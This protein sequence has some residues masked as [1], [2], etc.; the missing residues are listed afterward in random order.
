MKKVS[1]IIPAYNKA[2]YTLSTVQSVIAQTYKDIEIIV[3]DDGSTDKTPEI[4]RPFRDSIKYIYKK[5]AGASSARNL[6]IR[7]ASGQ[8]IAFLDCDDLYLPDK[9]SVSIDYLIQ[10]PQAGFVHT[11]AY[12]VD[13]NDKVLRVF[14]HPNS[15][16]TGWISESLI[17]RNFICNSTV[18]A[19]RTC[20]AK[21]GLFN[22]SIFT[23]ADWDMWLRFSEYCQAGY[24]DQPLT[25]YRIIGSYI[26]NNIERAKNE[27]LTVLREAFKRKPA[28]SP[29]FKKRALSNVF[30]RTAVSYL[31]KENFKNCRDELISSIGTNM[32]NLP[33][34]ALLLGLI[35]KKDILLKLVNSKV[36]N[37]FKRHTAKI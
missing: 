3:V 1:V 2:A 23:P 25:K 27:E 4:L 16:K 9:L 5:N 8:F 19:R 36:Y 22:E 32:L 20:I 14:S 33:S 26:L 17:L 31:L 12:F 15:K 11:A 29:F 10:N 21:A 13:E 24:I 30:R 28:L 35:L 34:I 6:G 18:V 7:L 37:D